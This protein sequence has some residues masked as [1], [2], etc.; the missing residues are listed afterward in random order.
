[1]DPE[2][3]RQFEQASPMR[4]TSRLNRL[5]QNNL[6]GRLAAV[7][8]ARGSLPFVL[9]VLCNEGV[10]QEDISRSLS[11]DRAAT[12]RALLQLEE[13]GF[14]VREEDPEDRRRKRVRATDKT[15]RLSRS[16]LSILEKQRE[17]LFAGFDDRERAQL[18]DMLERMTENMLKAAAP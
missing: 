16:I 13:G 5:H 6:A 9:E 11:I 12:A 18:L 7:G 14:V 4:M 3:I 8:I 1:V 15:R 2:K 10:I 17:I